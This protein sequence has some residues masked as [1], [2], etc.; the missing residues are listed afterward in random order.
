MK[1]ADIQPSLKLMAASKPPSDLR[2]VTYLFT[3][4]SILQ[5][6]ASKSTLTMEDLHQLCLVAYGWMPRIARLDIKH[7]NDAL[8]AIQIAKYKSLEK[9]T[10][11][12]IADLALCL[13]SVVGASKVLHFINPEIFPIWDSNIE[14]FRQ[15]DE[16]P[17][18]YMS[19]VANYMT[20]LQEVHEVRNEV[21]FNDFYTGFNKALAS[22]LTAIGSCIYEVTE[23][24]AVELAAFELSR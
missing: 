12:D 17:T 4:P 20:Y 3:Y 15:G 23:V 19:N 11:D 24:R 1:L 2:A 7:T 21:G 18:N 6:A 22:W 13:R 10:A 14:R 8:T 5:L 16:P 9:I